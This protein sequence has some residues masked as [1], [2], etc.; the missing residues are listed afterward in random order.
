MRTPNPYTGYGLVGGGEWGRYKKYITPIITAIA[1]IVTV[2][3]FFC[4]SL[5]HVMPYKLSTYRTSSVTSCGRKLIYVKHDLFICDRASKR[6]CLKRAYI[7]ACIHSTEVLQVQLCIFVI[8][9]IIV[10]NIR[11]TEKLYTV[12]RYNFFFLARAGVKCLY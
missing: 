2:Q 3:S 10:V 8:V 5:T 7:A 4:F 12:K 1:V 6:L 9:I 11:E